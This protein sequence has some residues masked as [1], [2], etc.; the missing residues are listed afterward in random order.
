MTLNPI[1]IALFITTAVLMACSWFYRFGKNKS[2]GCAYLPIILGV[3]II[4]LDTIAFKYL[5][6]ESSYI[7]FKS[8][9]V[10]VCLIMLFPLLLLK[11][12]HLNMQS[13]LA[14]IFILSGLVL[15][16]SDAEAP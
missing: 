6:V 9:M 7:I 14:I 2:N 3:T 15:I 12:R 13:L 8:L 4:A 16:V 5:S 1:V 11:H 10:K